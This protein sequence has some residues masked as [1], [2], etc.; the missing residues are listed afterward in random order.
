MWQMQHRE[1]PTYWLFSFC[2][3]SVDA[4][5]HL[6]SQIVYLRATRKCR[7]WWNMISSKTWW[8]TSLWKQGSLR[9]QLDETVG[10]F[11]W[12]GEVSRANKI[13]LREQWQDCYSKN[14]EISITYTWIKTKLILTEI[15]YWLQCW[16]CT[17]LKRQ[18]WPYFLDP[19]ILQ[20]ETN[21]LSRTYKIQ[22]HHKMYEL[23][24][25]SKE[26]GSRTVPKW[27]YCTASG[28]S[29]R[30]STCPARSWVY[31]GS[32]VCLSALIDMNR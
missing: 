32:L 13:Y 29:W 6:L 11:V 15:H 5:I 24:L 14:Q 26:T 23:L 27:S 9:E 2:L 18:A 31:Q 1:Q 12:A 17:R 19:P 10:I 3:F 21:R 22:Q 16:L 7:S 28:T 25:M 4:Q 30:K 20:V 8:T